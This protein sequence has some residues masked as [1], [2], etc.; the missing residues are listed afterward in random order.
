MASNARNILNHQYYRESN[1]GNKNVLEDLLKKAK[2][3][4]PSRIP[5]FMSVSKEFPGGCCIRTG[6]CCKPQVSAIDIDL[7]AV[8]W[9][10]NGDCFDS[11]DL[12]Y[13][14]KDA[15][16]L[17]NHYY[18][19]CLATLTFFRQKLRRLNWVLNGP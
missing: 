7:Y 4:A 6:G 16:Y 19:T 5:Y 17:S 14:L 3:L 12:F 8:F 15:I 9:G 18:L 2:Q 13:V 1:G 10:N 11:L